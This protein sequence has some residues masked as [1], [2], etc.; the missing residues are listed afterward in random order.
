MRTNSHA[1]VL[2]PNRQSFLP[3][4][5]PLMITIIHILLNKDIRWRL[6]LK[7]INKWIKTRKMKALL[8]IIRKLRQT[9]K[10]G[11]RKTSNYENRTNISWI[12]R[13]FP[14]ITTNIAFHS[15]K[16]WNNNVHQQQQQ[17]LQ[18]SVWLMRKH[19]EKEDTLRREKRE[20]EREK[21]K[22]KIFFCTRLKRK[23]QHP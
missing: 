17:Q 6:K 14:Y 16:R 23:M 7:K 9:K 15:S 20:R 19:W 1:N 10:F 2:N 3:F 11:K 12:L 5:L 13:A 22:S 21:L 18:C 8:R 4:S